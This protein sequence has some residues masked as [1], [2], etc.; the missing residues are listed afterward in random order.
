[1]QPNTTTEACSLLN[2]IK[3]E[4]EILI[5]PVLSP[6]KMIQHPT[7]TNQFHITKSIYLIFQ[8]F[9]ENFD[10]KRKLPENQPSKAIIKT[11]KNNNEN[12]LNNEEKYFLF[13]LNRIERHS[14]EVSDQTGVFIFCISEMLKEIEFKKRNLDKKFIKR[15]LLDIQEGIR[16]FITFYLENKLL[17][18][19]IEKSFKI[20]NDKDILFNICFTYLIPHVGVSIASKLSFIITEW[21]F[22]INNL[23]LIYKLSKDDKLINFFVHSVPLGN[24]DNSELLEGI[25]L[26]DTCY[27]KN[28]KENCNVK[29]LC[30]KQISRANKNVELEIHCNKSSLQN[31][32]I[33][34]VEKFCKILNQLEVTVVFFEDVMDDLFVVELLKHGIL[35]IHRVSEIDSLCSYFKLLPYTL[36]TVSYFNEEKGKNEILFIGSV[37]SEE[38]REGLFECQSVREI[39]MTQTRRFIYVE[40]KKEQDVNIPTIIIRAPTDSMAETFKNLFIRLLKYLSNAFKFN[41]EDNDISL[42]YSYGGMYYESLISRM[43]SD[44]KQDKEV[45][46][47]RGLLEFLSILEG[48]YDQLILRVINNLNPNLQ[49]NYSREILLEMKSASSP[50]SLLSFTQVPPI[51]REAILSSIKKEI[52]EMKVQS[53]F[54]QKLIN[55]GNCLQKRGAIIECLSAK[56]QTLINL[57]L[58]LLQTI[59]IE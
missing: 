6:C 48:I 34:N 52:T 46:K 2:K 32:V 53:S 47:Q 4:T 35:C 11:I 55:N 19:L 17:P 44:L 5:G 37:E 29:C 27:L 38:L 25:L 56:Y 15:Y 31:K 49:Q 23:N 20:K 10:F 41:D 57:C 3:E 22:K 33:E 16:I 18:Q 1:M 26:E 24:V 8:L 43:I 58:T 59:K 45:I 36:H 12:K 50:L 30:F 9:K 39:Q 40:P 54:Q 51:D 7:F 28:F 42:I 14:I 21:I 13:I